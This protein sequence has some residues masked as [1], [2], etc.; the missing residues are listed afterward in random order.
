MATN[1]SITTETTNRRQDNTVTERRTRRSA[2][3]RFTT[4]QSQ[5]RPSRRRQTRLFW[6]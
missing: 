5:H 1:D 3:I 6:V 2:G 4:R